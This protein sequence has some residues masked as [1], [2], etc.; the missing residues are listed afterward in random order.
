MK[1][2]LPTYADLLSEI[3]VLRAEVKKLKYQ[4]AEKQGNIESEYS[5]IDVNHLYEQLAS[6]HFRKEDIDVLIQSDSIKHFNTS[7][8]KEYLGLG[9]TN[10]YISIH[11][12]Q[13]NYLFISDSFKRISGY[14]ADEFEGN[15]ICIQMHPQDSDK[16]KN[17]ILLQNRE[18]KST[19]TRWRL[20]HKNGYYIWLETHTY[21]VFDKETPTYLFCINREISEKV[22]VEEKLEKT[23]KMYNSIFQ[24]SPD[25]L[26][27]LDV[28]TFEI[29]D[30]NKRGLKLF[31]YNSRNQIYGKHFSE[32]Q[33]KTLTYSE[34]HKINALINSNKTWTSEVQCVDSN[35]DTF[36]GM[37]GMR[38]GENDGANFILLRVTDLTT[39]KNSEKVINEQEQL[40]LSISQN[41]NEGIYRSTPNGKIIYANLA[42]AK[43]FG[44]DS[45]E[46]VMKVSA[47]DLYASSVQRKEI[48]YKIR[49]N[50]FVD[51][52][53]ALFVNNRGYHFWGVINC[54]LSK[55]KHG[56]VYFDGGIRDVTENRNYKNRLEKQNQE[57]IE[58]NNALDRF[59]YSASHD[60]RA[61]IASALGLIDITL[62]E[63][64]LDLIKEYLLLQEKSLR[65][66]DTFIGDIIDFSR[67]ARIDI[68]QEEI[69]FEQLVKNT[70]EVYDY[71]EN[72]S[73]LKKEVIINCKQPFYSDK[74]RVSII[75]NN[76][77]SN[78][79]KYSNPYQENPF[80]KVEVTCSQE[81]CEVKVS[82]NGL[83]IPE[84]H[85]ENIFNMFYRAHP[86]KKGSGLGLFIVKETIEKLK[87]KITVDSVEGS[88]TCFTLRLP[89]MQPKT[90]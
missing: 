86:D 19:Y 32:L 54:N 66:L 70:F 17:N 81:I 64:N 60:L 36:Y 47:I 79:I 87:G 85:I 67:N 89:N 26:F 22:M 78:A 39:I 12:L 1:N 15:T 20:K 6:A 55:G 80:I 49:F 63:D 84:L 38:K 52:E 50:G 62:R 4:S 46:E 72:A 2:K 73:L 25:A 56:E 9:D 16:F 69:S 48:A 43:M 24:S 90:N 33:N 13:S 40:I 53:E 34:I 14:N 77:L 31:K 76:L 8:I 82:D 58:V 11:N 37:M 23:R 10:E 44:Y 41:V 88:G 42:F 29:Y 35:G 59:V 51:N 30:C 27:L 18:G 57:L 7:F 68:E 71:M 65:K 21:I 61:P 5:E 83:G 45:V 28:N 3:S 74:S 75:L